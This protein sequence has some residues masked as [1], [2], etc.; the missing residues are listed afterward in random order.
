MN[1]E[2][3]TLERPDSLSARDEEILAGLKNIVAEVSRDIDE[4]RLYMAAEKAYHYVW[5]ELAD[6]ILEESKPILNGANADEKAARQYVLYEC[7]TTSLKL[8]HPF[9]PFV[10]E[11]IWQNLPKKDVEMLMIAAWPKAS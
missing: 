8:L 3:A 6:K 10:T 11:T 4:Y 7:L 1:V 2:G 9:M 5:S